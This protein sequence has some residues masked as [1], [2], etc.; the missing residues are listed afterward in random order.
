MEIPSRKDIYMEQLNQNLYLAP[1]QLTPNEANEKARPA[2]KPEDRAA[3]V[4]IM[5]ESILQN[6]QELPVLIVE[7]IE[8]DLATYE[9]IDGGCRVEAIAKLNE[10]LEGDTPARS[11]WCSLVEPYQDL[12]KLATSANIHRTQNTMLDIA[13]IVQEA[14]DRNGWKGKGAGKKVAEYLGIQESRVSEYQKLLHAPPDVKA[15]IESGELQTLEAAL[16]LM[17]MPAD[18]REEVG[19][20]AQEIAQEEAEELAERKG[21]RAKGHNPTPIPEYQPGKHKP[22]VAKVKTKH[23]ERA[24]KEKGVETT[25][26]PRAKSEIS[27]FFEQVSDAAYPKP[28]VAFADYFVGTWM[29]GEGSD[30]KARELFDAAVGVKAPRK[31]V[32]P[33]KETK[34]KAKAPKKKK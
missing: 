20:R 32:K 30:R 19:R 1:E 13:H 29:K 7:K 10:H 8:D 6:G 24:A 23:V 18:K 17:S 31:T 22:N 3:R 12:F 9:Y 33:P 14:F 2:E 26:T 28:A 11:V 15:K 34:P 27:E 25:S 21:K 4:R 16:K 5:A